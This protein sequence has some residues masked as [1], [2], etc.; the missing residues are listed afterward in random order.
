M[1]NETPLQRGEIP[2]HIGAANRIIRNRDEM[3]RRAMR[4]LAAVLLAV[5]VV[6]WIMIAIEKVHQ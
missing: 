6:I 3:D 5:N 4:F 1:R 2:R